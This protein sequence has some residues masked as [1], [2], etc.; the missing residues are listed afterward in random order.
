[1]RAKVAAILP[2]RSLVVL[3]LAVASS[4]QVAAML[5]V[6]DDRLAVNDPRP[7]GAAVLQVEHRCHCVITY[8]DPKWQEPDVLDVSG[9]VRHAPGA[10]PLKVPRG[11]VFGFEVPRGLSLGNTSDVPLL[12]RNIVEEYQRSGHPGS[13]R[14]FLSTNVLHVLPRSEALL[15]TP[16]T[17]SM[18][19][20][21]LGDTIDTIVRL[22]QDVNGESVGVNGPINL[23]RQRHAIVGATNE[24]AGDVLARCLIAAAPDRKI[25]WR[26]L[27]DFSTHSYGLNI[28]FVD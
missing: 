14:V 23:L 12:I 17:M 21:T 5:Q 1:M 15:D 3:T 20:R 7:L 16:I 24:R 10:P 6:N 25:S 19:D 8:E 28:H 13:Y 22:V 9:Q 18:V 11:G 2:A 27:Y 26:L 4:V